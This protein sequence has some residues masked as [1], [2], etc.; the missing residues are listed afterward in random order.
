MLGKLYVVMFWLVLVMSIPMAIEYYKRYSKSAKAQRQEL[1]TSSKMCIAFISALYAILLMVCIFFPE[2]IKEMGQEDAFMASLTKPTSLIAL[3]VSTV[4]ATLTYYW[5]EKLKLAHAIDVGD[6][7]EFDDYEPKRQPRRR[8]PRRQPTMMAW[9]RKPMTPNRD[10]I[11]GSTSQTTNSSPEP[12]KDTSAAKLTIMSEGYEK[13]TI[14]D[15]NNIGDAKAYL[16]TLEAEDVIILTEHT[17]VISFNGYHSRPN[18]RDAAKVIGCY[19]FGK[20][21]TIVE[22]RRN[23][24]EFTVGLCRDRDS[25]STVMDAF[26][27]NV[28]GGY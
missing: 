22:Q 25:Y 9:G 24:L 17:V 20:D 19:V 16:A 23:Y 28:D 26:V 6:L 8:Q 10:A 4:I 13:N 5:G 12:L 21:C 3:F 27:A 2:T 18:L 14:Y 7:S 11:F 15:F 1:K